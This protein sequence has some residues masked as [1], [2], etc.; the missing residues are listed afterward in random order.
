MASAA[1]MAETASGEKEAAWQPPPALI[2]RILPDQV[3]P[4]SEPPAAEL[5]PE[6]WRA[7]RNEA[8]ALGDE[9]VAHSWRPAAVSELSALAAAGSFASEAA[10]ESSLDAHFER[11]E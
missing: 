8:A 4:A 2:G 10:D 3:R 9:A 6:A 1:H 7:L 11:W 5:M